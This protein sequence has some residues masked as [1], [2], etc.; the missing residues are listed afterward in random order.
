MQDAAAPWPSDATEEKALELAFPAANRSASG[1]GSVFIDTNHDSE[2][3]WA[4]FQASSAVDHAMDHVEVWMAVEI[5]ND[6][7]KTQEVEDA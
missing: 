1:I 7:N 4:T 2:M 6:E 5:A 3:T